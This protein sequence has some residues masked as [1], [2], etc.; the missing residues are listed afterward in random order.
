[1]SPHP[2]VFIFGTGSQYIALVCLKVTMRHHARL[3]QD[4][5]TG[6]FYKHEHLRSPISV[7]HGFS[8]M[9]KA[10]VVPGAEGSVEYSSVS[11]LHLFSDF[12]MLPS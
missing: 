10:Q 6:E 5:I 2:S 1:M 12:R 4:L 11:G 3:K 8:Q 9:P 7:Q